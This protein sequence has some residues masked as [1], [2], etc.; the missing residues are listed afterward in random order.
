MSRWTPQSVVMK[1]FQVKIMSPFTKYILNDYIL[2]RKLK[3]A[4]SSIRH[5]SAS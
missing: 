3:T 5:Q 4:A 2:S 1:T